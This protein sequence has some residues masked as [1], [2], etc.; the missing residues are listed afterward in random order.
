VRRVAKHPS[1]EKEMLGHG[2]SAPYRLG[3]QGQETPGYGCALSQNSFR[4]PPIVDRPL[5]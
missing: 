3:Q 5:V 2:F 4:N 1:W